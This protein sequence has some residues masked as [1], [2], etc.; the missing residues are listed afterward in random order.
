MT[1]M[2]EALNNVFSSPNESDSNGEIANVVDGLFR[3][4]YALDGVAIA[5]EHLG[6]GSPPASTGMGATELLAREHRDGLAAIAQAISDLTE[7]G[8]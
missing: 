1:D 3:I 2:K 4:A 5:L 6:K 7:K 8:T